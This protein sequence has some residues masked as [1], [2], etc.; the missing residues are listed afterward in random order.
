MN[1][2]TIAIGSEELKR[3]PTRVGVSSGAEKPAANIGAARASL[4]NVLITDENTASRMLDILDNE[5]SAE[6]EAHSVKS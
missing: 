5:S 1:E 6:S 4:I 2:R 3:I